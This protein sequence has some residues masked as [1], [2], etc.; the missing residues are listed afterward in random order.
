MS[1]E[2]LPLLSLVVGLLLQPA[3][4]REETR[5]NWGRHQG[6]KNRRVS[7]DKVGGLRVEG[8]AL[9]IGRSSVL[10]SRTRGQGPGTAQAGQ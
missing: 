7:P 5:V 6:E 9:R 4:G 3:C 2:D 8:R 1:C 10:G